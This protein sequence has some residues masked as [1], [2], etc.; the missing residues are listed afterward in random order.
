MKDKESQLIWETFVDGSPAN[1]PALAAG[2]MRSEDGEEAIADPNTKLA[3][4]ETIT[5]KLDNGHVVQV[6]F[7]NDGKSAVAQIEDWEDDPDSGMI[8]YG[9]DDKGDEV[10]I[11]PDHILSILS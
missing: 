6:E 4:A 1:N 10:N 5:H 11:L 3:D 7:D 9:H 8:F 2:G